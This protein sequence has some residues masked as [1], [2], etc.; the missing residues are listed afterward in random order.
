MLI[1]MERQTGSLKE[2]FIRNGDQQVPPRLFGSMESVRR[3]PIPWSTPPYN[4]FFV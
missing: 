2:A 4:I 3:S 1:T